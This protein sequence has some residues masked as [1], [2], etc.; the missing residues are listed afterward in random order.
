MDNRCG[1]QK[2]IRDENEVECLAVSGCNVA[3]SL[4]ES[5]PI[6]VIK[7]VPNKLGQVIVASIL[8]DLTRSKSELIA[9]NMFLRQQLIVLERQVTRPRLKQRDRQILVIL[10]S[11]IRGWKEA[12]VIVKPDTCMVEKLP[13]RVFPPI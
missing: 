4:L 12:L 5:Q 2:T 7:Y 3:A 10:A 11:R 8:T 9:E 13:E 1:G 6:L